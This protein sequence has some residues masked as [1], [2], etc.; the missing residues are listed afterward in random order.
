MVLGR[1]WT[2]LTTI[3]VATAIALAGMLEPRRAAAQSELADR[4]I[5][6]AIDNEFLIDDSV[7]FHRIDVRTTDGV[8][9]LSGTVL[10]LLHRERAAEVARAVKGVRSVVNRIEVAPVDVGDR[11]LERRVDEALLTDPVADRYE[12]ATTVDDGV[13]TLT[14]QT[15]SWAEKQIA[16][17]VVRGVTG[18]R[19]V[20]DAVE[21]TFPDAR[22][23]LELTREIERRLDADARLDAGTIDVMVDDGRVTLSGVVGSAAERGRAYRDAWVHGVTAVDAD[24]LTVEWWAR[25]ETIRTRRPQL[26]DQEIAR[27]V[28]SSFVHDPRV[29]SWNPEVSVEDGV[30]TLSGTVSNLLARRTAEENARN[31]AGVWRVRNHLKV[32]PVEPPTDEEIETLVARALERDPYVNRTDV[33]VNAVNGVVYLASDVDSTWERDRAEVAAARVDGVVDVVN[34]IDVRTAW[35]SDW[36]IAEDVESHLFWNPGVTESDI[37]VAVEDGVVTLDGTVDNWYE[38]HTATAEAYQAG[39]TTVRNRLEVDS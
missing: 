28:E 37:S 10:H 7:P 2:C 19:E 36:E 27:S 23:D 8:V 20:V 17:D 16:L 31:T 1:R 4:E 35:K 14:G 22:P 39:A 26:S 34:N 21:I 12:L 15:D 9:T 38:V 30:V 11:A 32:R 6:A 24:G 18:V 13:V 3:F 29:W 5:S 25:D 33:I